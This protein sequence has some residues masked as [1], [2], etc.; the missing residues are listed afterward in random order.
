MHCPVCGVEVVEESVFCHKCGERLDLLDQQFSPPGEQS[1]SA[2]EDTSSWS[3][4]DGRRGQSAS[5]PADRI[6]QGLAAHQRAE[7]EPERF[8]LYEAYE[9]KD[10]FAKHQQTDHYLRWKQTAPDY[11]ARPRESVRH[12]SIFFGDGE[13]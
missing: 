8:L 1:G 13:A 3:G 7:D 5:S 12:Q 6:K 4:E 10:D 9:T 2:A 11:M